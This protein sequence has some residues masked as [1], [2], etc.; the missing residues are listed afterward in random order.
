VKK[1]LHRENQAKK[2]RENKK[3][4]ASGFQPMPGSAR[5]KGAKKMGSK[6]LEEA[7][8]TKALNGRKGAT[9][10]DLTDVPN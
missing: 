10:T 6:E 4:K 5:G 3:K 2:R 9:K 7:T 1:K 8:Q